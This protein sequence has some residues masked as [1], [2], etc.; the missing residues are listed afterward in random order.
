MPEL[1]LIRHCESTAQEPDAPLTAEGLRQA[2]RLSTWLEVHPVDRVV[3]SPFRRARETSAPLA[4]SRGLELEI[5]PRLAER[6]L[7]DPPVDDWREYVRRSFDDPSSCAPG[8]ESAREVLARA[9]A[10]I[11]EAV[12]HTSRLPALVTHGHFLALV[13]HSLDP[14]FGYTAWEGLRNPDV[15]R[16]WGSSLDRLGFERVAPPDPRSAW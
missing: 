14:D 8:G 13:L 5:D 15:F 3:S 9:W 4:T 16:L 12:E 2:E 7:A 6:R 11:A 10:T 1:L